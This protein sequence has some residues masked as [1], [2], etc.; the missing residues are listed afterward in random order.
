MTIK[1]VLTTYNTTL[2]IN[3]SVGSQVESRKANTQSRCPAGRV[4][5]LPGMLMCPG[6]LMLGHTEVDTDLSFSTV[7]TVRSSLEVVIA[8]G[9]SCTECCP[10]EM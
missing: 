5:A 7:T 3:S 10:L 9:G 6:D 2:Y 4:E 8:K 1:Q